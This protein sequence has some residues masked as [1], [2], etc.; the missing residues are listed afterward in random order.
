MLGPKGIAGVSHVIPGGRK[1][2][3]GPQGQAGAIGEPGPDG[4]D[5]KCSDQFCLAIS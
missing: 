3:P 2:E 1:G 5:G 4:P